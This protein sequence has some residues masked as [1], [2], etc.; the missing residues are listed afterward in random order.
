MIDAVLLLPKILEQAGASQ[1]MAE[2][3]AVIAWKRVAG[4]GLA[5]HANPLNLR[6]GTLIVEVADDVW[7][8][9]LQRMSIELISRINKL[10]RRE[11]VNEIQFRIN[12]AIG[13]RRPLSTKSRVGQ[14]LPD[15]VSSSAIEIEDAELRQRFIRAATNC[16]DR[17]EARNQS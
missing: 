17:R 7:R 1:E 10:L 4:D 14:S 15:N 11:I 3:A 6:G 2:A 5:G 13:K 16:I 8:R 12:P 9:Q